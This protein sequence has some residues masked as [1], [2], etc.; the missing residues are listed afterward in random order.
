M[1][2]LFGLIE[3]VRDVPVQAETAAGQSVKEHM[4]QDLTKD[5]W[6]WSTRWCATLR[7][8]SYGKRI[9]CP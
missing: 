7:P 6:L 1:G 3:L 8:R 5:I 9:A 4:Q 2:P